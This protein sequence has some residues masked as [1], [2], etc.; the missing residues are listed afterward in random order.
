MSQVNPP[1]YLR[2]LIPHKDISKGELVLWEQTL[3]VLEQIYR[4]IGGEVDQVSAGDE[5]I[6]DNANTLSLTLARIA[7]IESAINDLSNNVD[8]VII[9]ED[10]EDNEDNSILLSRIAKAESAINDL[11]KDDNSFILSFFKSLEKRI[12]DIEAQL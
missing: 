4:R 12:K 3:R 5:E 2:G 8:P 9:G 10:N 6:I 11:S 1:F 7:N